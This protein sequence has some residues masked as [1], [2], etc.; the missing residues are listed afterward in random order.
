MVRVG[1][2]QSAG[3]LQCMHVCVCAERGVLDSVC[4]RAASSF[5]D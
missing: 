1:G 2:L 5:I 4:S 3:K